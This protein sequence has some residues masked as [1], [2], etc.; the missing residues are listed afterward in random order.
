MLEGQF[1]AIAT[2]F[3]LDCFPAAELDHVIIRLAGSEKLWLNVEF[4]VPQSPALA[5]L[6]VKVI[7]AMMYGF[8]Q[9][10]TRLSARELTAPDAGLTRNGFSLEAWQASEW[11]LVRAEAWVR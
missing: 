2:C 1:D 3:F 4:A 5:L 10:T 8:F 11:G 7:H 6:R 9:L